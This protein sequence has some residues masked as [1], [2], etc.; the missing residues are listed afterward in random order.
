MAAHGLRLGVAELVFGEPLALSTW[1]GPSVA[2]GELTVTVVGDRRDAYFASTIFFREPARRSAFEPLTLRRVPGALKRARRSG[3][4]LLAGL[5][6]PLAWMLRGLVVLPRRVEVRAPVQETLERFER[7]DPPL[8]KLRRRIER[9]GFG[10]EV[11]VGSDAWQRFYLDFYAPTQRA[12]RGARA[13]LRSFDEPEAYPEPPEIFAVTDGGRWIA[14]GAGYRVED[15]YQFVELGYLAGRLEHRERG[16]GHALYRAALGRAR[17]R[18]AR[19]LDLGPHPPFVSDPVLHYKRQWGATL[20][21]R[22]GD[23]RV[24]GI[25]AEGPGARALAAVPLVF[26]PTAGRLG[27][28]AGS[29]SDAECARW[30]ERIRGLGV[31]GVWRLQGD[32]AIRATLVE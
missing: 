4:L 17:E 8:G 12:L 10:S 15:R 23:P 24:L 25:R 14:A 2:G 30:R 27:L 31:D 32:R 11:V 3:Q 26:E 18:G 9:A 6:T 21:S 1:R 13:H 28:L 22:H 5:P 16:A 7:G 20:S 19:L 29:A